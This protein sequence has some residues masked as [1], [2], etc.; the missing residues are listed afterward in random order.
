MHG[1]DR[2]HD[3]ARD[4]E[5][6][7]ADGHFARQ[8]DRLATGDLR[9]ADRTALLTW[10]DAEPARWRRCGLAF[11]EAQTIGESLA[12]WDE[13][14]N[15][16][17]ERCEKIDGS[18][19]R[20]G[21]T[22]ERP[23]KNV[24]SSAG[25]STRGKNRARWAVAAAAVTM[26][27]FLLGWTAGNVSRHIDIANTNSGTA[28]QPIAIDSH[29][30]ADKPGIAAPSGDATQSLATTSRKFDGIPVVRIRLGDGPDAREIVLPIV[31]KQDLADAPSLAADV[32]PEYVRALW[33]R[34]GY[35]VV[36]DRH[37]VPLQFADGRTVFMPVNRVTLKYVGL[38]SI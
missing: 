16:N 5:C 33:E 12:E 19:V 22:V 14:A 3:L 2:H 11:L 25:G 36:E 13:A 30:H 15:G 1:D 37:E 4:D 17:L 20:V 31:E 28:P 6:Q 21:V 27:A 9:E 23:S 35:Q 24:A 8:I 10:L 18:P 29:S 38:P 32:V 26:A 7:S 34:Q